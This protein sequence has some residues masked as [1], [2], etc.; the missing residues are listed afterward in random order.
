[1]TFTGGSATTGPDTLRR[2]TEG[3]AMPGI[4][5]IGKANYI[6]MPGLATSP[7]KAAMKAMLE[8]GADKTKSTSQ[9]VRAGRF[10]KAGLLLLACV[11]QTVGL[12]PHE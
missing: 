7:P 12:S 6:P 9:E 1:M 11:L 10:M 5:A 2:N 8:S 3:T 4:D